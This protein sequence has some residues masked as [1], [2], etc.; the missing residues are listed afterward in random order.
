MQV[1]S[2]SE[3]KGAIES[4]PESIEI[5]DAGWRKKFVSLKKHRDLLLLRWWQLEA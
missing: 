5:V 1:S 3:L 4:K 2:I